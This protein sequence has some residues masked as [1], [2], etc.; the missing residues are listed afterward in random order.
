MIVWTEN[1][2]REKSFIEQ[3][4]NQ[5]NRCSMI[6]TSENVSEKWRKKRAQRIES[7]KFQVQMEKRKN[8]QSVNK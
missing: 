5:L 8:I 3:M 7:R 6:E 2:I 4:V 1:D